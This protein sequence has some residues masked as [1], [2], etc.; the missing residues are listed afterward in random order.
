MGV[1]RGKARDNGSVGRGRHVED[2]YK[3]AFVYDDQISFCFLYRKLYRGLNSQ[4]EHGDSSNDEI[5]IRK[6]RYAAS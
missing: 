6:R 4:L 3:S 5:I 2:W 1:R